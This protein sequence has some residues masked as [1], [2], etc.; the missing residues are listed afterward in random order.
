MSEKID[1]TPRF[2]TVGVSLHTSV[3]SQLKQLS[4]ECGVSKS[5]Y[6]SDLI[7]NYGTA[8]RKKYVP[9]Q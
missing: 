3:D 9:E 1:K 6:V 2:K 4:K 8:Q 5:V 7:K